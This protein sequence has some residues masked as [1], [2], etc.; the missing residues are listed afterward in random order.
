MRRIFNM[1][2]QDGN[3]S[4][5][6]TEMKTILEEM[7]KVFTDEEVEKMIALADTD[8]SGTLEYEEFIKAMFGVPESS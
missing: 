7:G 1:F 4:I 2:D 8:H 6:K 3:G 5:D